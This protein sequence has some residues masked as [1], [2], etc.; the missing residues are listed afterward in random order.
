[1]SLSDR[2]IEEMIDQLDSGNEENI[3]KEIEKDHGLIKKGVQYMQEE[4]FGEKLKRADESMN[5]SSF[6][7]FRF[8]MMTGIAA[9]LVLAL[10]W[11]TA[12]DNSGVNGIE[13]QINEVPAYADSAS[14]DSIKNRDINVDK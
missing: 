8:Y 6:L 4:S 10:F 11:W 1:M 9:S 2:E 14:Y 13:L 12:D 3:P 7:N 5:G